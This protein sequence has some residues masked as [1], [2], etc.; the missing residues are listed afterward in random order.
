MRLVLG[1]PNIWEEIPGSEPLTFP[2]GAAPFRGDVDSHFPARAAA[3]SSGIWF[4]VPA[5][6]LTQTPA[7]PGESRDPG[8]FFRGRCCDRNPNSPPRDSQS[9]AE[10]AWVPAFAGMSG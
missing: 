10:K 1:Q 4:R 5:I 2:A 9:S 6:G 7:H 3:G 8:L